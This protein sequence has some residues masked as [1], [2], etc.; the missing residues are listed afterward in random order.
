[1]LLYRLSEREVTVRKMRG[2]VKDWRS[3]AC[4]LPL[5]ICKGSWIRE[6]SGSRGRSCID[7]E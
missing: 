5:E 3:R 2:L 4:H 7:G 1:M 6:L